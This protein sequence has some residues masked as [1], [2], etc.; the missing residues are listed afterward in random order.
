MSESNH[1]VAGEST[2]EHGPPSC[3]MKYTIHIS[4]TNCGKS[5]RIIKETKVRNFYFRKLFFILY[6]VTHLG[7]Y[8]I[9]NTQIYNMNSIIESKYV[10]G[11]DKQH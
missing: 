7:I 1:G 5:I 10:K 2:G 9:Y 6:K 4:K 8:R 3:P 11:N